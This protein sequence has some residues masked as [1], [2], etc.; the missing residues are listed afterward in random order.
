MPSNN[1]LHQIPVYISNYAASRET[2]PHPP[3]CPPRQGVR[4]KKAVAYRLGFLSAGLRC[5]Y[6]YTVIT[7]DCMQFTQ[8]SHCLKQGGPRGRLVSPLSCCDLSVSPCCP[9]ERRPRGPARD[10][11]CPRT[12]STRG[13]NFHCGAHP[14]FGVWVQSTCT[15]SGPFGPLCSL[16]SS[17]FVEHLLGITPLHNRRPCFNK[18]H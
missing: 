17:P 14:R 18:A 8:R 9:M 2:T 4:Q 10:G 7:G 11:R 13:G 5:M 15:A 3:G 16:R 12:Y 6:T 1:H